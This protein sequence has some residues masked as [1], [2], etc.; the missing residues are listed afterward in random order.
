MLVIDGINNATL[1]NGLVRLQVVQTGADGQQR[2]VEEIAIPAGQYGQVVQAL[3]NVG[4]QL[5]QQIEQQQA[6]E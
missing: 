4:Q 2:A 3:T 6:A 1:S 5:R